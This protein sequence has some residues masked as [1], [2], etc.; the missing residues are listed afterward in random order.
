VSAVFFAIIR[1]VAN[2]DLVLLG[3]VKE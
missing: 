1:G 2:P 3:L